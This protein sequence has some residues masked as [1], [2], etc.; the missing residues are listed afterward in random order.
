[1]SLQNPHNF[2]VKYPLNPMFNLFQMD[3]EEG[4][5]LL[6]QVACLEA[7]H[8]STERGDSP[9]WH[10]ETRIAVL[11]VIMNW[12]S[13]E[14][15]NKHILWLHEPAGAG[16][17]AHIRIRRLYAVS[18]T[19]P[20]YNIR[21]RIA[22]YEDSALIPLN[23]FISGPTAG[24]SV[25]SPSSPPNTQGKEK[26]LPISASYYTQLSSSAEEEIDAADAPKGAD[27]VGSVRWWRER[28]RGVNER[29]VR[30]VREMLVWGM[31]RRR[32]RGGEGKG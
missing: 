31:M 2:D 21:F 24:G 4:L 5:H 7:G 19:T 3:E 20:I 25:S 23:A 15:L 22:K 18:F 14:E 12:V 9:K 17:S 29:G 30:C 8:R 28:L 32:G 10:P 13:S 11:H 16:K 26:H 27:G 6:A 1:M